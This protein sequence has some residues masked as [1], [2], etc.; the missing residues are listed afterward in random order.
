[1][2]RQRLPRVGAGNVGALV[3]RMPRFLYL[4]SEGML[5]SPRSGRTPAR[6]ACG[7]SGGAGTR[8]VSKSRCRSSPEL[9]PPLLSG[10]RSWIGRP[11]CCR[12]PLAGLQQ[13]REQ[14]VV[15]GADPAPSRCVSSSAMADKPPPA[16]PKGAAAAATGAQP[17]KRRDALLA[18]EAKVQAEWEAK[19]TFSADAADDGRPKFFVTF[20]CAVRVPRRP[21]SISRARASD[22]RRDF[23]DERRIC[24]GTRPRPDEPSRE[25]AVALPASR[26]LRPPSDAVA[27]LERSNR[28][29]A[30]RRGLARARVSAAGTRT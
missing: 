19:A 2:S 3:A 26:G 23:G 4:D 13:R 28:R 21:S 9:P 25:H 20:P 22:A 17:S 18:L 14:L 27:P 29:S 15:R 1:M 30:R 5:K 24:L 11:D 12:S 10:H 6:R 8:P 7:G 16:P